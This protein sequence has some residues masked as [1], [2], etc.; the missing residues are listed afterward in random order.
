MIIHAMILSCFYAISLAKLEKNFHE[1]V[2]PILI[3]SCI[4]CHNGS[5]A[6][7]GLSLETMVSALKGGEEGPAIVVGKA[8][9][10]LL[11]QKIVPSKEGGKAEMPRKK[12]A[13]TVEEVRKIE[14][15]I[16]KG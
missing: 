6:K 3:R 2:A 12:A 7:G 5:N 13:L 1:E 14:E 11:Y 9:E 16:D 4:E 10:S 8:K 15:W